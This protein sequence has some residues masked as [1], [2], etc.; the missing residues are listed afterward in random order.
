M[1]TVPSSVFL[2]R[3]REFILKSNSVTIVRSNVIQSGTVTVNIYGSISIVEIEV[4]RE[5]TFLQP[6][7]LTWT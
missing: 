4:F 2:N 1:S 5:K 6:G 7:P 3:C